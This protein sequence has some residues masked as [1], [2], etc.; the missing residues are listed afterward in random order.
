MALR[1][2]PYLP[3][4]I[5][6]FLTDEKLIECSASSTGIYI[7]LMCIMHKSEE[8]GTILLKQKDKQSS[9]PLQNFAS[10]I[11]KQLPYTFDEVYAGLDEL[12]SEGVIIIDGDKLFQ[13]RMVRDNEISEIR[14]EAGKKGG[15]KTQRF[16][17][18]KVKANSEYE[19]EYEDE[20]EDINKEE[21]K[22][23]K[24]FNFDFVEEQFKDVFNSWLQYKKERKETYKTQTSLEA[25]YKNLKKLSGNNPETAKEIIEN[26]FANNWSG[27]FALK[28]NKTFTPAPIVPEFSSGPDR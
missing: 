11:A 20:N 8:Y 3:L 18:A 6:D 26:S 15:L 1:D 27:L 10:K 22:G 12:I 25:C 21:K 16:A 9:E 2:Q 19:Y 28:N 23:A 14:S 13:K 4:Y 24:K 5:Q 17:K 7:R